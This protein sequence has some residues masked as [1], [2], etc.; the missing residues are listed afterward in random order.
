M[1]NN[2]CRIIAV[3]RWYKSGLESTMEQKHIAIDQSSRYG[4]LISS[5]ESIRIIL[6]L[7]NTAEKKRGK[8]NESKSREEDRG[9][10]ETE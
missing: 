7:S 1:R 3:K 9:M 2:E 10:K 5:F 6:Y 8:E 4:L